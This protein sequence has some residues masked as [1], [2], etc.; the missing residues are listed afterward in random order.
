MKCPHC[1]KE[2][3][4]EDRGQKQKLGMIKKAAKGKPMSR[5]A[6]G[7]KFYNEAMVPAQNSREVEEIFEEFLHKDMSLTKLAK[8]HNFSVNGMKKI[9]RNFTY[10]GK[11]KFN[12]QI[13]EG[14]HQPLISSTLFNKVQDELERLK[15]KSYLLED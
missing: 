5:P 4:I 3:E 15:R 13:H 8:K 6:F 9:L 7:Y 12:G 1:Q 14:K 10:I 2:I 11:I